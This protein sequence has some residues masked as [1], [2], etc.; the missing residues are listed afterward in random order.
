M[1]HTSHKIFS[2]LTH[3]HSDTIDECFL[4]SAKLTHGFP[5]TFL[6]AMTMDLNVRGVGLSLSGA[7]R[8]P[9][10]SPGGVGGGGG[11]GGGQPFAPSLPASSHPP[12]HIKRSFDVAF[13]MAPDEKF[14]KKQQEKLRLV[15]TGSLLKSAYPSEGIA[16]ADLA[17]I[18]RS[19]QQHFYSIDRSKS[20]ATIDMPKNYSHKDGN[21]FHSELHQQKCDEFY[22]E[23]LKTS[24]D[25]VE[26]Y[27][28]K[29]SLEIAQR[30]A[31]TKVTPLSPRSL[32][33]L[34]PDHVNYQGSMSPSSGRNESP[35]PP[36]YH[37]HYQG[38]ASTARP[39][40]CS[41]FLLQTETARGKH[42]TSENHRNAITA[43]GNFRAI[44][45]YLL[46]ANANS[47][48]HYYNQC[49]NDKEMMTS[50]FINN[51]VNKIRSNLLY[52]HPDAMAYSTLA[53]AYPFGPSGFASASGVGPS[54]LQAAS[55][56]VAAAVVSAS[57]LPSSFATFSLP[58]Q[59]VCA[60]C[61]ISFRMTSDLVYHMRSHHKGDNAAVDPTRRRRD[62]DKLKCPVCSESFRE[63]HHLTRHMTAHQDKA[64][65]LVDDADDG[66]AAEGG[67]RLRVP[68][69]MGGSMADQRK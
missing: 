1:F 50:N 23:K 43:T 36:S 53:A 46:K 37:K 14:A 25:R 39:V 64:G 18:E 29:A 68:G 69:R 15:A 30:S 62:Q 40:N 7:P 55:P 52:N 28:H 2:R 67:G 22:Q 61:N 38:S 13:L 35:A 56:A 44:D 17:T 24:D 4:I 31:F 57:L 66:D 11:G 5:L 63:R 45:S 59:N 8:R 27:V 20:F 21:S 42:V 26:D 34:S 19:Y 54:L 32:S 6:S 60:K 41:P 51:N 16:N 3:R 10:T 48:Q 58:A 65:D 47:V 9:A 49:Q 12:R 33:S